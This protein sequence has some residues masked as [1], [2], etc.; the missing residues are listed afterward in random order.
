MYDVI[1]VEKGWYRII[2]GSGE[3]YLYQPDEFAVVESND[4]TVPVSD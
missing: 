1:S 3:D 4:G 2:D